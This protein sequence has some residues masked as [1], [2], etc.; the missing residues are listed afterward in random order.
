MV[1][2]QD[3]QSSLRVPDTSDAVR[4]SN[5]TRSK[6]AEFGLAANIYIYI[7]VC[8]CICIYIEREREIE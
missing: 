6:L 3:D 1:N 7:Y 5:P 2:M 8:I 4:R